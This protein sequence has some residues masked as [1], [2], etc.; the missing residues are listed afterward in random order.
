M[1]IFTLIIF[2][3]SNFLYA[4]NYPQKPI[5]LI[6]PFAPSGANDILGRI[7]GQKLS[8]S[9]QQQILFDNR[10]GAGGIIG[11]DLTAKSPPD[12]YTLVVGHIGT[13]GVNPTLYKNLP[14]DPIKDFQSIAL[15]AKVASL[16]VVHPSLP[17]KNIKELIQL[18]KKNSGKLLYGSGGNGGAGHLTTE[19]F[20]LMS[21]TEILHIPY[22]GTGPAVVDLIAGQTQ[23]VFGGVPGSISFVKSGRLR[24][25]GVSTAT[26][27]PT[28]PEIP[29]ISE[30]IP[31][32]EATQWYGLLAPA[33]TPTYIV[34]K[35][36]KEI[37]EGLKD[38]KIVFRLI[39]NGSEPFVSSPEEF[40]NFIKS[41]ITRWAPVIKSARIKVD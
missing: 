38:P 4:Q 18:A 16:L 10:P 35:L 34:S 30:T 12:G 8:E 25:L 7:I 19:Y 1:R 37:S 36:N 41:E 24:A 2:L 14:Y 23:I 40:T 13:F 3:F 22:K 29:T 26:R 9:M 15:F 28:L 5:R 39:E 27:I 17:A 11:V 33:G 31:G 6:I 20:K 32:F 21:K